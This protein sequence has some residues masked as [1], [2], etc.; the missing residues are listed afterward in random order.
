[1]KAY[2]TKYALTYGILHMEGEVK[3]EFFIAES[4]L[5]YAHRYQENEWF[6]D[7]DEALTRAEVMRRRRVRQLK[8]QLADMKR[9][10]RLGVFVVE[11]EEG[12]E[13]AVVEAEEEQGEELE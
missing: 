10:E 9:I 4:Q 2:I 8:L 13:E 11:V 1:M 5:E 6:T 3:G 12:I 7:L